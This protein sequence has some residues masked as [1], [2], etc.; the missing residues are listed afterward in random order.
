MTQLVVGRTSPIPILDADGSVLRIV[1]FQ[2]RLEISCHIQIS[3]PT[4]SQVQAFHRA[5]HNILLVNA[6]VKTGSI[7][8]LI[9]K[10]GFQ[11]AV[12]GFC[13]GALK[14][15]DR[16]AI[17]DSIE[18]G[19]WDTGLSTTVLYE[20]VDRRTNKTVGLRGVTFEAGLWPCLANAVIRSANVPYAEF[21]SSREMIIADLQDLKAMVLRDRATTGNTFH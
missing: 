8:F 13:L 19:E 6:R 9:A 11:P 7:P 1:P 5:D 2:G 10:T 4:P 20:L 16:T 17:V 21:M 12:E 14:N 15:E 3:N 18:R